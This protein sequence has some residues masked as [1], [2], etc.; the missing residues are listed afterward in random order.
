MQRRPMLAQCAT[1]AVLFG[2]SDVVAQ[3]AVEKRGWGSHDV[4]RTARSTFYGG[5]LFGPLVT[6]WFAFLNRLTFKT[7]ARGVFW[8]V[9]MDQFMFT[10]GVVA[11]Y[12]GSMTLLE[13]KGVTEAKGRIEKAYVPTII[14]NWCVCSC[15][16]GWCGGA[17]GFVCLVGVCLSR[18]SLLTLRSCRTT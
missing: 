6:T 4:A 12:F 3:Q 2:A 17:D 1:S 14:R 9:Y 11:F 7:A 18:R 10:P 8:R 16:L 15:F 13:G 5:A